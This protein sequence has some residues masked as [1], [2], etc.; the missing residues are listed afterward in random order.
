MYNFCYVFWKSTLI[1]SRIMVISPSPFYI[2]KL[3]FGY[4]STLSFTFTCVYTLMNKQTSPYL[5]FIF[6]PVI[7]YNWHLECYPAIWKLL[8]YKYTF[9]RA[10]FEI[11]TLSKF[12][13]SLFFVYILL[14]HYLHRKASL[15]RDKHFEKNLGAIFILWRR[16]R[17]RSA[18]NRTKWIRNLDFP[19]DY[20]KVGYSHG[21]ERYPQWG[22]KSSADVVCIYYHPTKHSR[23]NAPWLMPLKTTP[24]FGVNNI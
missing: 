20:A 21:S 16:E 2:F 15:K 24:A 13:D 14:H 17:Q 7:C 23:S 22:L 11:F 6:S 10:F 5:L 1:T 9:W 18:Q 19:Y 8:C 12:T 3:N 4:N